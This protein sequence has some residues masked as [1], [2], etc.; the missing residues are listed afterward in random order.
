MICRGRR[1]VTGFYASH[2]SVT[3][4]VPVTVGLEA[5]LEEV[6]HFTYLGSAVDT[7]GGTEADVKARIG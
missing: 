7:Q 3:S 6:E 2:L 4:T 5:I 1:V